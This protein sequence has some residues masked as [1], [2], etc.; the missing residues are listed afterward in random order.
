MGVAKT[1]ADNLKNRD[2]KFGIR[3]SGLGCRRRIPSRESRVALF[4]LTA[5]LLAGTVLQAQGVESASYAVVVTSLG[6]DPAYEK[7]I[8]GWGKDLAAALRKD[9]AAEGR[10]FWLGALKEDAVH[11]VS[12]KEE[13]AKLFAEL[14]TRVRPADRFALFLIGHGSYDEYDY[15]LSI[16]G[17][18]LTAPE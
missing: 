12:R 7:V 3:D 15:R 10:V 11:A 2:S 14:A 9:R 1:M 18:D 13:I 6:G 8:Q 17:P 4:L 5:L 16:P